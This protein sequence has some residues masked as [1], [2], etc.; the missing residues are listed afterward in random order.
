MS[1]FDYLL[2]QLP[3]FLVLFSL[4]LYLICKLSYLYWT[5]EWKG[6]QKARV[7]LDTAEIDHVLLHQDLDGEDL[8]SL[9]KRA[10]FSRVRPNGSQE[11]SIDGRC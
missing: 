11:R 7:H 4:A 10:F 2:D 3:F 1:T 5:G 8:L 9:E 6:S